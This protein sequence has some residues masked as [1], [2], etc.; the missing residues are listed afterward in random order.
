MAAASVLTPISHYPTQASNFSSSA[1]PQPHQHSPSNSSTMISS[2]EQRRAPDESEAPS[3]QSLPSISEVI[4]GARPGQFPP[5]S[6]QSGQSSSGLPSP[7][8]SHNRQY[9]E[10]EKHHSSPQPLHP[11]SFTPRQDAIPAFSESPRPTFS[12][13]PGFPVSDRRP[14]P[15]GK[16][17]GPPHPQSHNEPRSVSGSYPQPPPPMPSSHPY[18]SAQ[19]PPGQH[20]LPGGYPIS[21]RHMPGEYDARRPPTHGEPGDYARRYDPQP[22]RHFETWSYQEAFGRVSNL[23]HYWNLSQGS[24]C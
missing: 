16:P 7:F 1:Y 8:A 18:Q 17:D 3:R 11:A 13:R 15:P 10:H 22:N 14:T 21:P 19:L 6:H 4:S 2:S 24:E 23:R 9:P 12:G 20:P 5:P